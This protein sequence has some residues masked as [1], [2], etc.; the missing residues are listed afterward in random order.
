MDLRRPRR[1]SSPRS[2]LRSF[3]LGGLVGAAGAVA[4]VRRLHRSPGGGQVAGLAAFEDAPCYLER[5]PGRDEQA[6]EAGGGEL[7]PD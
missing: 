5:A 3:A 2:P 4:A 1:T 6:G 7:G